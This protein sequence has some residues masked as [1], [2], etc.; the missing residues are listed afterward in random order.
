MRST[1]VLTFLLLIGRFDIHGVEREA[2]LSRDGEVG[3]AQGVHLLLPL[4]P[5]AALRGL[6]H[7]SGRYLQQQQQL[8]TLASSVSS[9]TVPRA[10]HSKTWRLIFKVKLKVSVH[11]LTEKL[12]AE[13]SRGSR[14]LHNTS[15]TM[16]AQS[17]DF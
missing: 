13:R 17:F 4:T 10:I 2:G 15:R 1:P 16:S 5:G 6:Q 9:E 14:K 8:L 12:S 11:I 3:D 7:R